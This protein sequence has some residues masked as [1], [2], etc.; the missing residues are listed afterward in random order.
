LI[1]SFG[2]MMSI[3]NQRV[4]L[5]IEQGNAWGM[6]YGALIMA[7]VAVAQGHSFVI[8]PRPSYWY[9]MIY[10]SLF[11][12]VIAFGCYMSLLGKI[13]AHKTSYSIILFPAVDVVISTIVEGFSWSVYTFCGLGLIVMGNII[14]LSKQKPAKVAA[15]TTT[16]L[17]PLECEAL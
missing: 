5:P 11:G 7:V 8:D 15:P 6:A 1:A 16:D 13:G 12:S 17:E 3:S 14:V 9:S 2:N 4:N 10:L